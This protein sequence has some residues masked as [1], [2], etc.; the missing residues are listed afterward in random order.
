MLA[1]KASEI[2]KTVFG[3]SEFRGAQ[4]EIVNHIISGNDAL[5]LM[6][7]GAGKSLC[8]QVPALA[9]DGLTIVISP[10][11]A[12][13]QDQVTALKELGIKAAFINSSL[14]MEEAFQIKEAMIDGELDIVYVAPER[15]DTADFLD[16]LSDCELTLFA[17]DEAHCVS[18]WGHDFRPSYTELS[19][20]KKRFPD[21]PR[22]ALTATADLRTQKDIIK[23]LN[24]EKAR[25][26]ISSFDRKNIRY[27]IQAKNNEKKQLLDFI[28][29]EHPNDSGIVYCLSRAKVEKITKWLQEKGFNAFS[30]HAGLSPKVREKNQSKFIKEE[31]VIMVATIA[32]GMGIDKPDVRFVAHLDLPKS[33]E[34]Y[35]Q[36]TGRA[37]R[38]GLES[39]AWMVYGAEDMVKLR[40]FI[41]N[42][43]APKEQK[44]I[45]NKKLDDLLGLA[46]A[47]EC[48]RRILLEYFD[49]IPEWEK[50]NNCDNCLEPR[51]GFDGTIAVQKA[52]SSI[53]R[54][55]ERFGVQYNIN[56]LLGKSDERT[57]KLRHNKLSTFGIGTEYTETQWKSI[58]RQMIALNLIE[59]DM[60][61]YGILK[62]SLN[63]KEVLNGKRKISLSEDIK[64][65]KTKEKTKITKIKTE[66]DP[67]NEIFK[68]LKKLRLELAK[69]HKLAPYMV[70]HDATLHAMA[71][72]KP[73]SLNEMSKISGVGDAKLKKYGQIFLKHFK[74]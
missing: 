55:G 33:I 25:V 74:T 34:A 38:D 47:L 44:I 51:S 5:V 39:N 70:F 8:Y 14:N 17:I 23:Y 31:S 37:G 4:E 29:S 24:L 63:S 62:L 64:V 21:V 2:L 18:Q 65:N 9:L 49:E 12:L 36:E 28:N 71:Q 6:P 60:D 13:M 61:S 46:E 40:Q 42:S 59:V 35:Y 10:L 3:Y 41:K 50:C 1:N 32:F 48:R 73:Q 58:F 7:T 26:F 66:F 11:I 43:E 22:M 54:T 19:K 52:L 57:E 69:E 56:I 45:E 27:K 72:T 68:E 67:E 53:Y 15:L 20:L 16:C 30:Y